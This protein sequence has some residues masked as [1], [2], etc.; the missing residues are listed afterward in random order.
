[1]LFLNE[2]DHLF[3]KDDTTI[4]DAFTLAAVIRN[5]GGKEGAD[6]RHVLDS[7]PVLGPYVQHE[8]LKIIGRLALNGAEPGTCRGVIGDLYRVID[9]I[10]NA[11]R[12]GYRSMLANLL[13]TPDPDGGEIQVRRQERGDD[14]KSE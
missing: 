12:E 11:F 13:P 9:V 1:M 10:G 6:R 4:V 8:L 2:D 7:E 5:Q 14:E 3:R